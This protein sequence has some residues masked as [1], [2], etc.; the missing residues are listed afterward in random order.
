MLCGTCAH[1]CHGSVQ[2]VALAGVGNVPEC[3]LCQ[4]VVM[5]SC[6]TAAI[7][8]KY[9]MLCGICAHRYFLFW[10]IGGDCDLR[11]CPERLGNLNHSPESSTSRPQA[12]TSRPAARCQPGLRR[13]KAGANWNAPTTAY[14]LALT[15]CS[16]TGKGEARK[17]AL[18]VR[19]P[20][21]SLIGAHG[22]AETTLRNP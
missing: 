9:R 22:L 21:C 17:R 2:V 5:R 6:Q 11:E 19:K 20:Q 7:R 8:H 1:R 15:I 18:R 14:T 4:R 12:T 10:R 16:T 13:R 3:A